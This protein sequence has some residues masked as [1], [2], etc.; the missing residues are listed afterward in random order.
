MKEDSS[1][2]DVINH[3]SQITISGLLNECKEIS[4]AVANAENIVIVG[5]RPVGVEMAG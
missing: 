2:T 5:G 3:L 1:D 4:E